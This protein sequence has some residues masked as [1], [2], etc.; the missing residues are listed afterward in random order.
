MNPFRLPLPE[1]LLRAAIA[2]SFAYPA[3]AAIDDPDSWLGYFPTFIPADTLILHVFGALEIAFALWILFSKR[4]YLP[5]FLAAAILMSIVALNGNQFD[6]LFRDVS[7]ALAATALGA[8]HLARPRT[9][10]S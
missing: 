8:Y 6:I 1:L 9:H 4:P 5:S 2:F 7:L 10:A 3:L